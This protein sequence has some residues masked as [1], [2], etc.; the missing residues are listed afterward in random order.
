MTH[1]EGNFPTQQ[2]IERRAY[3]LYMESGFEI[4]RD[5]EYW[6][7]AE[8]ELTELYIEELF[9]T[10]KGRTIAADSPHHKLVGLYSKDLASGEVAN[11]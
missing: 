9:I 8:K 10:L 11:A 6:L 5:V 4:G 7:A 1:I 3:E 2:E